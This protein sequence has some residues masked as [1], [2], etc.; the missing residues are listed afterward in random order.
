MPPSSA[1]HQLGSMSIG[2]SVEGKDDAE[3]EKNEDA[4]EK[5]ETTPATK[6]LCS[7]CGKEGDTHTL[8]KCRACKCVW[9]CDKDCQN[10]HWKEHKKECRLI[11]KELDKRGG[12]LD[13]G[14]EKDIGP[15]GKVPPREECSICMQALPIDDGLHS[16][17]ACCGK[18]ICEA[19]DYQHRIQTE[20]VN[21]KRVQRKQPRMSRA[22]AFC[23]TA[24]P[25]SDEET[26]AQLR[27]RVELKDPDAMCNMALHHG[28]GNLGFQRIRA[29]ALTFF[30]SLPI[31]AVLLLSFISD[32]C[33]L[34]ARWDLIRTR[35]KVAN[36]TRKLR[37][38]AAFL[39]G[40]ILGAE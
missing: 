22:C 14:T 4:E 12:K 19:C 26:L 24:V 36:T 5:V 15:L 27:K 33:S 2:E 38:E 16:Y 37:K 8:K 29:S 9:Y 28:M 34:V 6:L 10:K 11:K 13:L 40:T 32:T 23:R 3:P 25:E 31:L 18:T 39:R 1:A 20:K 21:I 17:T 7:A 30:A 35:K